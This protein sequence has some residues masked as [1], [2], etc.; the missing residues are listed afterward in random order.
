M[1]IIKQ[2]T[3]PEDRVYRGVCH[4]CKCEVEFKRS[5]AEFVPDQ[6]DGSFLRVACPCCKACHIT[7]GV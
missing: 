6:R 1:K 5:E 4:R 3:P 2:G 7:V